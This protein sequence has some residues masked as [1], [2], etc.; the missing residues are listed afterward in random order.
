LA[1]VAL[2]AAANAMAVETTGIDLL[3]PQNA[4]RASGYD[5]VLA[6]DIFYER[7]TARRVIDFLCHCRAGGARVLIGDP[8]R[9]Y[10]PKDR[11]V[12]LCEYQ[13]PVTREL[14]DQEI[15][16]TAVWTLA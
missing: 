15:K 13:I 10:L 12:R 9:T 16:R 6:A 8:G 4:A 14:E 1:A 3:H 2:N 11:L 5:L 7:E